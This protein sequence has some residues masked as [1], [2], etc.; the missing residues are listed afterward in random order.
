VPDPAAVAPAVETAERVRP[1]MPA[2]SGDRPPAAQPDGEAGDPAPWPSYVTEPAPIETDRWATPDLSTIARAA[3]TAWQRRESWTQRAWSRQAA[4]AA[5][6]IVIFGAGWIAASRLFDHPRSGVAAAIDSAPRSSPANPAPS[7][8]DAGGQPLNAS[9]PLE[10]ATATAIV[11]T[12][13]LAETVPAA[14][15]VETTSPAPTPATGWIVIAA[16]AELEV[17]EGAAL[18]GGSQAGR[19]ALPAGAHQ[20]ELVSN[21]LGYRSTRRIDVRANET[22][23]I[24][25]ELPNGTLAL[26]ATPWAEVLVDG[27]SVGETPIGNLPI[28]VG[29]HEIVFRHPELGEKRVSTVV[30]L[31][32][33]TRLS[34]DMRAP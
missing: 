5:V 14:A 4:A 7:W 11:A 1:T 22:R 10:L 20:I 18:L 25:V 8:P 17:Y 26:N 2:A 27:R 3:T 32:A 13:V 23:S 9:P 33:P 6:L 34:V 12:T 24:T 28:S 16:P 21:E 19:I 30:T 15:A 29:S 31:T